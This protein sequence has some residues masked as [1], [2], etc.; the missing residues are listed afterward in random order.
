[1][2][3]NKLADRVSGSKFVNINLLCAFVCAEVAKSKD[4]SC[5]SRL[6]AEDI[7]AFFEWYQNHRRFVTTWNQPGTLM[8]E[9]EAIMRWSDRSGVG[10]IAHYCVGTPCE[11][12]SMRFCATVAGLGNIWI[13]VPLN[14]VY[15]IQIREEIGL[16][17]RS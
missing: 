13:D 9:K 6:L 17:R 12:L 5:F 4:F 16:V 3:A 2:S 14:S 11:Y 15:A 1:M 8:A 10:N 7:Q